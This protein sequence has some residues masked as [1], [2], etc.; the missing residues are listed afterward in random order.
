MENDCCKWKLT[1]VDP[2]EKKHLEIRYEICYIEASQ[3]PGG[4]GGGGA[5]D[6]DD[7]L[8]DPNDDYNDG[9]LVIFGY[10]IQKLRCSQPSTKKRVNS[11]AGIHTKC[12]LLVILKCLCSKQCDPD[13]TAP[14]LPGKG[15][16]VASHCTM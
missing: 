2:Q 9:K 15:F 8:Q 7:A 12:R 16:S 10:S 3:L 1:T 4:G 13:Q 14:S 11:S 6:V 5:T